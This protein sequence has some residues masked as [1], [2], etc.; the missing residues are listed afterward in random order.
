MTT[1]VYPQF[2]AHGFTIF[3]AT[4]WIFAKGWLA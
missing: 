2:S 1:Q 4:F 3:V